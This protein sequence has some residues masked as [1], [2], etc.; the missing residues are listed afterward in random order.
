MINIFFSWLK[1]KYNQEID[2]TGLA[3]FRMFFALV[4]FFEIKHIADFRHLI[5]DSVPYLHISDINLNVAFTIWLT[6]IFFIFLGLLTRLASIVNYI[7]SLIFIGSIG[8]FEYHV[9]YAYMGVNFLIMFM[10][11]SR[12]W[13]LDWLIE[14]LKYS[15]V[16]FHYCPPISYWIPFFMGVDLFHLIQFLRYT[17]IPILYVVF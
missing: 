13:S 3:L 8:D 7:F 15:N 17:L 10:P 12:V 16:K 4:L 1:R 14:K 11:V 5:Y 9:Y 6:S 2:A